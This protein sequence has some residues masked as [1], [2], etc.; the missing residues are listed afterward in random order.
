MKK[1]QSVQLLLNSIDSIAS[2]IANERG[3]VR[4]KICAWS[5]RCVG[6]QPWSVRVMLLG[7]PGTRYCRLYRYRYVPYRMIQDCGDK[8]NGGEDRQAKNDFV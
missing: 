5:V 3:R 4:A 6:H 1:Q 7:V 8:D 2:S